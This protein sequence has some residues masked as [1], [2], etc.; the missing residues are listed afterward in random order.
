MVG[1]NNKLR[2]ALRT[3]GDDLIQAPFGTPMLH[4]HPDYAKGYDDGV[5]S[6]AKEVTGIVEAAL[7]REAE[8]TG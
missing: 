1:E 4:L 3:L 5:H 7:A 6:V 8:C 2:E